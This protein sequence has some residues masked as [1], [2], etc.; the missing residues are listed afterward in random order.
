MTVA[1]PRRRSPI[2]ESADRVFLRSCLGRPNDIAFELVARQVQLGSR[3][4]LD[5][6]GR[7]RLGL[8]GPARNLDRSEFEVKDLSKSLTKTPLWSSFM[9][10]HDS[11]SASGLP[12]RMPSASGTNVSRSST[13]P[14]LPIPY[15]VFNSAYPPIL[16]RRFPQPYR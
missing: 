3:Y 7:R 16:K 2:V 15:C 8:G 5:L 14:V 10:C 6:T 1:F 9:P 11:S 4:P 13:E 12:S